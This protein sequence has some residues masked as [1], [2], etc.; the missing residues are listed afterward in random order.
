MEMLQQPT[1]AVLDP[2]PDPPAEAVDGVTAAP[3]RASAMTTSTTGSP[4]PLATWSSNSYKKEA[5]SRLSQRVAL[6]DPKPLTRRSIAD[7]LAKAFPESAVAAASTCEELLEIDERG[8]GR[9]NLVVVYIRSLGFSSAYV[10][11]ALEL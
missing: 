5:S 3:Q 7:L 2:H 9:P 11:N 10:Q 1:T 4:L 8:I 6:I